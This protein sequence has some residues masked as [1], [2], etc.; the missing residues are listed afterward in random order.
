MANESAGLMITQSLRHLHPSPRSL[1]L[2]R[3]HRFSLP[4]TRF[5]VLFSFDGIIN[6]DGIISF[7]GIMD[8]VYSLLSDASARQVGL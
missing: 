5:D 4:P 3:I 1:H 6:V 7:D 2:R 8:I